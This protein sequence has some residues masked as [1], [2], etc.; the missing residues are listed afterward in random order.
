MILTPFL[1][2][3]LFLPAD[4]FSTHLFAPGEIF[5]AGSAGRPSLVMTRSTLPARV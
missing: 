1:S 3:F 5:L 2:P 4:T